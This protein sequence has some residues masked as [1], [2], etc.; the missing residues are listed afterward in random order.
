M[1]NSYLTNT[2]KEE[3]NY[4]IVSNFLEKLACFVLNSKKDKIE[5]YIEPFLVNFNNSEYIAYLFRHF[6]LVE[7]RLKTYD[8]F[9]KV[10]NLFKKEVFEIFSEGADQWNR[11]KII[12]SFLFARIS[13]KENATDWYTLKEKTEVSL[14]KYYKILVTVLQRCI[15]YQ[16]Y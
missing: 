5:E 1:Y 9:W 7:D 15:P 14:E 6:I 11:D 16:N 2:D 8:N 4:Y 13:W 3:I 10:W 12:K